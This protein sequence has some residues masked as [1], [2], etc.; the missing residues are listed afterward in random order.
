MGNYRPIPLLSAISKLSEKVVYQQLY[1]YFTVNKLSY[2][3]QYCSRNNHSCEL[4]NIELT[5]HIIPT[6][7]R[8]K[9]H[10]QYS[11]PPLNFNI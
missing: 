2:E 5:R 4:P 9:Y 1:Q 11:W 8:K 6:L 3:G 10:C 7:N